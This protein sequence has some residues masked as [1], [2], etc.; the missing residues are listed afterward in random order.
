MKRYIAAFLLCLI[1]FSVHGSDT[2]LWYRQP[3][4]KWVEAL[5]LGNGRLGAMVFGNVSR[6]RLQLNEESLWAGLPVDAYPDNFSRHL[7]ELQKLVLDGKTQKANEYGMKHMTKA[8]TSFRSYEPL[9]DLWMEFPQAEK[10]EDYR[11]SLN[12][13]TGIS[14]VE[15]TSEGV[16]HKREAFISAVDD[17]MAVRLSADKPGSVTARISLTREKD[18]VV[19]AAGTRIA[20]D[21]Q[22]VDI[23]AP[24]G[25]DDNRGGSGPGGE[26]MR[27]AGRLLL[28]NS[29]GKVETEDGALKVH[30]ADEAVILFTAR[31]DY[32]VAKLCFDR[33]ILTGK[34]SD[35]ILK[36]AASKTWEELLRDHVADHRSLFDRVSL[37][38]GGHDA[39]KRPTDERLAALKKGEADP[40]LMALYF[41][42]GRYLLMASSH[43]TFQLPAN[44]Q[45]IWNDRMW[46]PWESD[47]HLNINLQMN[48][49]PVDQCNLSETIKP[50]VKWFVP[51][52]EKG[53]HS[54]RKLYDANGWVI[55]TS[56]NPFGRTTPSGSTHNS[57]FN[58]GVLDPLAGAWMAMT[59]WRHYEFTADR[60]FLAETAYPVLKGAAEF[61]LDYLVEDSDGRLVVVPSTSPENA[62]IHPETGKAQRIT[63]G[64]VYSMA[65][66]RAVFES[67]ITGSETLNTDAD[68]RDKLKAALGKFPAVQI[69]ANGTI[70]EWIEDYEEQNPG[71]RHMSH[72]IGLH[73]FSQITQNDRELFKAAYKTI[74]RRLS[75]GGGHT[76]WSR[77][78]MINFYARLLD[79]DAAHHHAVQLLKKSTLP[80]LF[81]SHPPFQIDG[82]FGGTSGIAEMLLQ[83]HSGEIHLLPALPQEWATGSVRGLKARGGFVVDVEWQHGKLLKAVIHSLAG[84]QC[85]VRYGGETM[86]LEIKKGERA[87]VAF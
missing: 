26:H 19:K 1:S 24:M 34:A 37:D 2:T 80:N 64:S 10:A 15:Y 46:A 44:L 31:T 51:T 68:F 20:M 30:G 52:T 38:L 62:Y 28:R 71:H 14:V 83:S 67:V 76:G 61:L 60:H 29:G 75:K 69:G 78:W 59:L 16:R 40:A 18:M 50:L 17:V 36:K 55:F 81:D 65:I 57:Q 32:N 47:Y 21:G 74:E 13:Q 7:A 43:P 12:L 25:Y 77:A 73:P 22:I 23:E 53:R 39:A 49:W 84:K 54:A 4:E 35:D 33:S 87:E 72:L 9:A 58:N 3:A 79:G 66:V 86:R 8:P 11:R 5:P 85:V 70:Q 42:Y 82:N 41:Q 27:F 56:T 6:D 63:K 45:G 48:Y